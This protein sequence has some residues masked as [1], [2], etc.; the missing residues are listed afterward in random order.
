MFK[1]A[2]KIIIFS[3]I[4]MLGF[5]ARAQLSV[6]YYGGDQSKVGVAFDLTQRLNLEAKIYASGEIDQVIPELSLT[7]KILKRNLYSI[8]AGVSGYAY[9]DQEYYGPGIPLGTIIAPV[10]FL[11]TLAFQIEAMPLWNQYGEITVQTSWAVRYYF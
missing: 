9:L 7:Y 8:Y 10:P 11:K 6:A 4:C 5:S 1:T 2:S 3:I